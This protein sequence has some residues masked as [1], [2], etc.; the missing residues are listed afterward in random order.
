MKIIVRAWYFTEM[1]K[2]IFG[3]YSITLTTES[4]R[5]NTFSYFVFCYHYYWQLSWMK[6]LVN[7]KPNRS[8][9]PQGLESHYKFHTINSMTIP[10]ICG[11]R[12]LFI[13]LVHDDAIKWH[14]HVTGPLWGEST[15]HRWILLI[16]ASGTERWCFHWCAIEETVEQ[17]IDEAV[18]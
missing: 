17:I 2:Q 9:R 10:S 8:T 11:R 4:I 7:M 12:R 6:F 13:L 5:D 18:I 15:G 1:N 16:K 3:L 14:F